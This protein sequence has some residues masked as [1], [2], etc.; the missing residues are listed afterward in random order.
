MDRA[1]GDVDAESPGEAAV[2]VVIVG[3]GISGI[4]AAYHLKTQCPWARTVILDAQSSFGGTW[5]T[6]RYP[7]IRS[8]TDLY[9]YGFRFKPW[10]G[11]PIAT[12][13]E[14]LRYMG[15][16]IRENGLDAHIRYQHT[17]EK[18]SWSSSS[19]RWSIEATRHDTGETVRLSA[20]FLWMCQ[21]YYRHNQGYTPAWKELDRF[22]GRIVHPET[23][24]ADLDLAGKS[25]VVIGSG[26][27][28]A[29]LVPAIADDCASL[30]LLQRSPTFFRTGRNVNQL[31]AALRD[32]GIDEAWVHETVRRKTL[33]DIAGFIRRCETE[34][35]AV[36]GE[37]IENVRTLLGPDYDVETHFTPTYRPWQQRVAFVP[38]GDLFKTIAAG[39]ASVV[40]EAIDRFTPTGIRLASGRELEADVVVT[41]TGFHLNVMGDIAFAVD[42]RPVVWPETV[43]YRGMMFTG[44]PNLAWVFGYFRAGWTLRADLVGDFVCRLLNHMRVSGAT[45]VE[46]VLRPEDEGMDLLPWAD[47]DSFNPGYLMRGL[48]L[49][50]RR[51]STSEW[52]HVQSYWLDRESFPAI[53]LADPVFA[54][55]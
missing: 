6:H 18:A 8:D 40:T 37:L 11:P 29:T 22:E 13:A 44:V 43:T 45:A 34:P 48:H 26:A 9:T 24:P 15:E 38:D 1:R 2:D 42:E 12:A 20:A 5:Q 17:V 47:T 4:A 28:A 36:A 3:A 19:R 39:K 27:T 35:D 51:G 52:Q 21:G 32:L 49:L 31:A 23:W 16:V 30:T 10:S 33:Q 55:R 50:P 25:V 14:I 53:D 7:G 46:P 41:A 54:Y